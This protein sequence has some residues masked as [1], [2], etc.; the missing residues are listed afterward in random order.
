MDLR[1]GDIIV[2]TRTPHRFVQAR[3][4]AWRV[5]PGELKEAPWRP[6]IAGSH[7]GFSRCRCTTC[8]ADRSVVG[9]P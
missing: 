7:R 2:V 8:E 6:S 1:A 9:D 5:V 3:V 4:I